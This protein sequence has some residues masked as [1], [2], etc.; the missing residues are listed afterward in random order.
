MKP[1]FVHVYSNKNVI[2][3]VYDNFFSFA[4]GVSQYVTKMYTSTTKMSGILY[5]S[6]K[7]IV[8]LLVLNDV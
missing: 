4:E 5:F 1:R 2:L 8:V 6:F 3:S 7:K